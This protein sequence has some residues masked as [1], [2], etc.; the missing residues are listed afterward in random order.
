MKLSDAILKGCEVAAEN[1]IT[2]DRGVFFRIDMGDKIQCAC[3]LGMAYIGAYGIDAANQVAVDRNNNGIGFA[4]AYQKLRKDYGT[5]QVNTCFF[6]KLKGMDDEPPAVLES[7][8]IT[9]NDSAYQNRTPQEIA[10]LL[11]E[12]DL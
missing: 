5:D 3:A 2:A 12:C 10:A 11:K 6:K 8:V 7:V 4:P 1:G 9:M